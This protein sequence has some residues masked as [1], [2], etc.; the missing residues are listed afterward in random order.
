MLSRIRKRKRKTNR[1]DDYL[2]RLDE[3][4]A[5]EFDLLINI[6]VI[7]LESENYD[8]SLKFFEKALRMAINLKNDELEA[9][10]LDS[11]RRCIF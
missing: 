1:I 8:E 7:Y 2:Q 4:Q 6:G 9:F 10:V 11:N 5:E 3:L